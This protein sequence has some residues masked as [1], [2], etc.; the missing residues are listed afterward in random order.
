[1]MLSELKLDQ[2]RKL[3]V[4]LVCGSLR[5]GSCTK[6]ALEYVANYIESHVDAFHLD[7][8]LAPLPFFTERNKQENPLVIEFIDQIKNADAILIGTPEYHGSLTGVLKN[9]LDYLSKDELKNKPIALVAVGA[10]QYGGIGALDAMSSIMKNLHALVIPYQAAI[11]SSHK[12][13]QNG[14][15]VLNEY[16]SR[17]EHV[18]EQLLLFTKRITSADIQHQTV[19]A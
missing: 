11:S 15:V 19:A 5:E 8:Q 4:A 6:V 3:R 16:K 17:L 10:G 1:M 2:P 9:A 12:V 7:L 14:E 18:A 13:I